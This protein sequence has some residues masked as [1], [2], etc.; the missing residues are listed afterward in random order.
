MPSTD[1]IANIAGSSL[2]FRNT[3]LDRNAISDVLIKMI[4]STVPELA[5]H[6]VTRADSMADLGVDSMERGDVL[7]ATLEALNLEI[8]MIQL[9]GPRSIGELADR[10]YDKSSR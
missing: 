7:V 3:T 2:S 10:I 6:P 8:P 4:R 1:T 5:N 9:H